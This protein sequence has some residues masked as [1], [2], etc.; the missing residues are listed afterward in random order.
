VNALLQKDLRLYRA[1]ICTA[2]LAIVTPWLLLMVVGFYRILVNPDAH[3]GVDIVG[4]VAMFGVVSA[5]IVAAIF[6]GFAFS[7]ERREKSAD[8]LA[9][10]PVS[11]RQV[12]TSKVLISIGPVMV[13]WLIQSSAFFLLNATGRNIDDSVE[14]ADAFVATYAVSLS[15]IILAFGVAW[16]A[17]LFIKSPSIS[18]SIALMTL[19]ASG[20]FTRLWMEDPFG[21][22]R[23]VDLA[24]V[25]FSLWTITGIVC[26]L[27]GA[28]VFT[29]RVRP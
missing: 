20:F 22:V 25:V 5:I 2:A 19:L 4:S 23:P 14:I 3:G 21:E 8:F 26:F 24:R 13:L 6:G 29:R 7:V 16:L 11:R 1:P 10:L 27:I 15:A 12:M 9:M 28:V 17:G 18:A